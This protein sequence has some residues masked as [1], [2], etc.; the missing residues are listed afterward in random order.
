MEER[1]GRL[2]SEENLTDYIHPKCSPDNRTMNDKWPST[3][4]SVFLPMNQRGHVPWLT[5]GGQSDTGWFLCHLSVHVSL[6]P[7]FKIHAARRPQPARL[8]SSFIVSL[9]TWS[10]HKG[11]TIRRSHRQVERHAQGRLA[12]PAPPLL[13]LLTEAPDTGGAEANHSP[14]SLKHTNIFHNAKFWGIC[15]T[16]IG[17]KTKQVKNKI[18]S[19]LNYSSLQDS[20]AKIRIMS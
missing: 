11:E 15:Y 12:G 20:V 18:Q 6:S 7:P 2:F 17:T 13:T 4:R 16:T 14:L 8:G 1:C 10:C 5:E 19:L 9:A 3:G